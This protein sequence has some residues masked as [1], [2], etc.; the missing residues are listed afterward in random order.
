MN[1]MKLTDQGSKNKE[2][3]DSNKKKLKKFN[4]LLTQSK[5]QAALLE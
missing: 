1:L 5:R 3:N 2:K 4:E